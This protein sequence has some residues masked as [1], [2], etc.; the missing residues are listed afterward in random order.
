MKYSPYY[1]DGNLFLYLPSS[2]TDGIVE[3]T[4]VF[5]GVVCSSAKQNSSLLFEHDKF[6]IVLFE[7]E[8]IGC[9][10]VVLTSVRI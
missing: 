7:G 4:S 8:Q 5:L 10:D 9:M 3:N 1:T 6:E 2:I